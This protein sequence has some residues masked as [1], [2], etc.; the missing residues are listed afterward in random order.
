MWTNLCKSTN[1]SEQGD[2]LFLSSSLPTSL[3]CICVSAVCTFGEVSLWVP[4]GRQLLPVGLAVLLNQTHL[5]LQQERWGRRCRV[6]LINF[7]T[8]PWCLFLFIGGGEGYSDV[9]VQDAQGDTS[10]RMF[11]V[12]FCRQAMVEACVWFSECFQKDPLRSLKNLPVSIQL[13]TKRYLNVSEKPLML[14]KVA[15]IR[16]KRNIVRLWHFIRY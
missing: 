14:N 13:S 5:R 12:I 10:Q 16:F 11:E 2:S 3:Q 7:V 4:P 9:P 6:L 15:Y 8:A 1:C